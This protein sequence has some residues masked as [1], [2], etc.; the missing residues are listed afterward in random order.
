MSFNFNRFIL[1]VMLN[2]DRMTFIDHQV[3][4]DSK[5]E[6]EFSHQPCNI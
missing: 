5:I 4:L 6:F 1:N 3:N 2:L